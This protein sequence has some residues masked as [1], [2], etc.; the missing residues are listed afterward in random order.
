MGVHIM[1][2]AVT[3]QIVAAIGDEMTLTHC[4]ASEMFERAC[5]RDKS[6]PDQAKVPRA[7][8][9]KQGKRRGSPL[10]KSRHI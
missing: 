4:E 10:Q 8:L 5:S 9:H 6:N 3:D 1:Q 7:R 2:F